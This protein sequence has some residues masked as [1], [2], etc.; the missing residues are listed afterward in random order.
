MVGVYRIHEV[1]GPEVMQWEEEEL[2]PP[3]GQMVLVRH[4]AIGLNYIDT[5]HRSGL[6]PMPLPSRLGVEAAGLVEAVGS[7][8]TTLQPG[9]RVACGV[10]RA[11]L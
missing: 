9:D 6:Y 4:V 5:Y 11:R 7:D 3:E 2:P 1:G 10:V 8:V